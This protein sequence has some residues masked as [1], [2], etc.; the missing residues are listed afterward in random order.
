MQP[1]NTVDFEGKVSLLLKAYRRRPELACADCCLRW[2]ALAALPSCAALLRWRWLPLACCHG[3]Y[4]LHCIDL[5]LAC[6]TL[7][8]RRFAAL[9]AAL[10]ETVGD[11]SLEHFRQEY[12]RLQAALKKS[13]ASEERL[14]KKC[15]ELSTEII[16]GVAKVQTALRLSEGDQATISTLKQET[17]QAWKLVEA[18][19]DKGTK[20]QDRILQLEQEN[21]ELKE[22]VAGAATRPRIA[23]F[24]LL[25]PDYDT[26]IAFFVKVCGFEL[27]EDRDEGRK[28]WVT[29]RPPGAETSIVLA[30]ADTS[31]QRAAM[32]RQLG[33]R[34]GFFLHTDN[35]ARD[36]ARMTAAKVKFREVPR[37]EDY[38][39]VAV[40]EDPW[41]NTW[42]LLEPAAASR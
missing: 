11:Q 32:G 14:I 38:G 36:H 10:S 40:W 37:H 15:K 35:F 2:L 17:E 27:T 8:L 1:P 29:V 5:G 33:G 31:E 3:H 23:A 7:T 13:Q 20:A 21:A 19:Q 28:R 4:H 22:Q 42:D 30:R 26:A 39:T 16:G 6:I 41:G 12:T 34:V 24:S 9:P 25:V 18:A